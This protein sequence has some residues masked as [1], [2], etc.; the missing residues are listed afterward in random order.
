M[1][2][3]CPTTRRNTWAFWGT[4]IPVLLCVVI[5]FAWA[6][7]RAVSNARQA[8]REH[9]RAERW[10]TAVDSLGNAV[11]LTDDQEI[12]FDCNQGVTNMLGWT[13]DELIGQSVGSIMP[14]EQRKHHG[15]GFANPAARKFVD[16]GGTLVVNG[17]LVKSKSNQLV[18]VRT[19]VQ[20][21]RGLDDSVI[22]VSTMTPY[23]K[24][25]TIE[26]DK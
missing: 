18:K 26:Y 13:R 20:A 19:R 9:H 11:I 5:G 8:Q 3:C 21:S 10:E 2:E 7:D 17:C 24:I 16:E 12:I 22:Y 23:G 4:W 1:S 25:H 14:N 15:I 6:Y